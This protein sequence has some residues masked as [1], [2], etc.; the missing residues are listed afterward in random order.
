MCAKT[1]VKKSSPAN[2]AKAN[3]QPGSF[4]SHLG[5]IV[6]VAFIFAGGLGS[7]IHYMAVQNE[8]QKFDQEVSKLTAEAER[9]TTDNAYLEVQI[10]SRIN[11]EFIKQQIAR[12]DLKL[13]PNNPNQTRTIYINEFIEY[14]GPG[15]TMVAELPE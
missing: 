11:E 6:T 12:F 14:A 1:R 15:S 4:K 13:R 7:F 5:V 9:L 2:L 3:Q 8:C 10:N